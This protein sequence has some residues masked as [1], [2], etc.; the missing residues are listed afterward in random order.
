MMS[1][2]DEISLQQQQQQQQQQQPVQQNMY[3][4]FGNGMVQ[5]PPGMYHHHTPYQQMSNISG[6][7]PPY[8]YMQYNQMGQMSLGMA[9]GM[10]QPTEEKQT[11][12]RL[13]MPNSMQSEHQPATA[14]SL[15]GYG[16]NMP[17]SQN[18]APFNQAYMQYTAQQN[19]GMPNNG[20]GNSNSR[21]KQ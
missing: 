18:G 11:Y 9:P 17:F 7:Y 3:G 5:A 8:Q 4:G 14:S 15:Y 1:A 6:M 16:A 13:N 2:S 10:A 12:Q 19:M 20:N 21:Q